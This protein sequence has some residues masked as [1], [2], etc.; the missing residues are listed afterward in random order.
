MPFSFPLAHPQ[1]LLTDDVGVYLSRPGREHA[2]HHAIFALY[3]ASGP[4]M[5]LHVAEFGCVHGA[6]S[7]GTQCMP[8]MGVGIERCLLPWLFCVLFR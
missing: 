2:F 8:C 5:F 6:W 3:L 1:A 7:H 4:Q